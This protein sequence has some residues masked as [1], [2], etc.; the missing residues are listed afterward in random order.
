MLG[1]NIILMEKQLID[2]TI[3]DLL[4]C[5]LWEHW[6]EGDV[7][8]VRPTHKTEISE[9]SDIGHI[10]LTEFFL[11]NL[12]KYWGFC[13]PQDPSG[14]DYIQPVMFTD[15]GQVQFYKESDWTNEE[16]QIE[17][18]KI[19]YDENDILPLMLRTL[20]KCDGSFFTMILDNFNNSRITKV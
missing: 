16:I 12:S 1:E 19:G 3:S 10:V 11:N 2:L 13:S 15:N 20:V 14:L 9:G 4:D 18:R 5:N 8:F 7:E 6:T 17:M